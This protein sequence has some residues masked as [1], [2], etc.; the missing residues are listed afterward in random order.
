[1]MN[2]SPGIVLLGGLI[3]FSP[4]ANPSPVDLRI[5]PLANRVSRSVLI[6]QDHY[7]LNTSQIDFREQDRDFFE[8]YF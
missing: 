2:N 3:N 4:T 1:M 6:L 8:N 7:F 5:S